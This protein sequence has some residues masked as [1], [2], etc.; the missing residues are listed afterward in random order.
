M[1]LLRPRASGIPPIVAWA[2]KVSRRESAAAGQ[3]DD[4]A[5]A[6]L[7]WIPTEVIGGYQ[8]AI[9]AIPTPEISWRIG[10]TVVG[11][12]ICFLWIL[13]AT[14]PKDRKLAWRQCLVSVLAFILWAVAVQ[15]EV[16]KAIIGGWQL[17]MGTIA[18]AFSPVMLL[19]VDGILYFLRV[20]QSE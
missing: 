17:W 7:K 18:L 8:A 15:S 12:V 2:S 1:P 14:K 16:L 13:F 4:A 5:Q 20:P 10:V 3:Q 6:L 19:I 11:I 9:A